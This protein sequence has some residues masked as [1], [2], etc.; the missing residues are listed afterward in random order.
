[1]LSAL[2][3]CCYHGGAEAC[4]KTEVVF[5]LLRNED[6]DSSALTHAT[7]HFPLQL[8]PTEWE[9]C[10][11]HGLLNFKQV[12]PQPLNFAHA[13]A[14]PYRSGQK[15][16]KKNKTHNKNGT[17]GLLSA[18]LLVSAAALLTSGRDPH[19]Q[20]WQWSSLQA[21]LMNAL[22]AALNL[23]MKPKRNTLSF[24]L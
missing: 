10:Y 1:M 20:R 9:R 24:H 14:L 7:L 21:V 4:C 8:V 5:G 12:L 19:V 2:L 3:Q 22:N 16:K 17:H 11:H 15:K 23:R 13:G 18:N 6:L